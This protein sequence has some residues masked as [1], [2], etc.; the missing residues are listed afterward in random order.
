MQYRLR[1]ILCLLAAFAIATFATSAA[2]QSGESKSAS[3]TQPLTIQPTAE[4]LRKAQTAADKVQNKQDS[5]SAE[6]LKKMIDREVSKAATLPAPAPAQLPV[7]QPTKA[8]GTIQ[9]AASSNLVVID[10]AVYIRFND[11]I[12]PMT[13]GGASGC[14][15][16][17]TETS[18]KIEQ[19]KLKF[20]ERLKAEPNKTDSGKKE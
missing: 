9:T 6:E 2:Q 5:L 14:F 19:A 7:S 10:G 13:G 18:A 4:V 12:V 1:I 11:T 15:S 3:Q 8:E 20:A 17:S 16:D